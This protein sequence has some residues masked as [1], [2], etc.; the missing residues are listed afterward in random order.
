MKRTQVDVVIVGAGPAGAA[1]AIVCASAGR[2]VL[3]CE[4]APFPRYCPGETLH[5]A[6]ATIFA[7]LGVDLASLGPVVRPDGQ[8]VQ[9]DTPSRYVEFG[10]DESGA[11]RGF[12]VWRSALDALLLDR[13]RSVGA[14]VSQPTHCADVIVDDGVV[15]GVRTGEC[16]IRARITIDASG[17]RHWLS[18]RLTLPIIRHSPP[19]LAFVGYGRSEPERQPNRFAAEPWGWT[20]ISPVEPSLVSWTRMT[21]SPSGR[22]FAADF[23]PEAGLPMGPPLARDVSW[24]EGTSAGLGYFVAGDAAA[25]LDPSTGRGVLM[26]LLA[27]VNAGRSALDALG[28][29]PLAVCAARYSVWMERTYATQRRALARLYAMHPHPPH[30]IPKA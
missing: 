1:A 8:E 11:W 4:R 27:G 2:R 3:L 28:G 26:A 23:P 30:W 7:T 15:R 16:E 9:W 29:T 20:W 6:V 13:A 5:P 21:F 17:S 24:R 22:A 10:G 25:R 12:Q 18:R 14:E 19:L